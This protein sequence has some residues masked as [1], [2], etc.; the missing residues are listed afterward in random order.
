MIWREVGTALLQRRTF[1]TL[2][3]PSFHKMAGAALALQCT[4]HHRAVHAPTGR[5]RAPGPRL[6]APAH[7]AGDGGSTAASQSAG[8]RSPRWV[9]DGTGHGGIGRGDDGVR[10]VQ[11]QEL[12]PEVPKSIPRY[13]GW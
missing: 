4:Q 13:M 2:A 3:R 12:T 1:R 10:C 5:C 11:Q 6:R 9:G 8:C 7:A